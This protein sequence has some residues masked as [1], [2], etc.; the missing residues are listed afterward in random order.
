M[1]GQAVA[2][3]HARDQ[4]VVHHPVVGRRGAFLRAEADQQEI[5]DAGQRLQ[6]ELAQ[7]GDEPGQPDVVVGAA[8]IGVGDVLQRRDARDLRRRG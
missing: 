8:G 3:D 2:R 1:L 4:P 7:L 6:A 5:A